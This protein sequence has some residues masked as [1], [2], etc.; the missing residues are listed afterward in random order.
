MVT[1]NALEH[2]VKCLQSLYKF[3]DASSFELIIV[4]N[5]S[6]DGTKGY[7][8][9]FE[10][11]HE[12]CQFICN[13]LNQGFS[14][15]NNKAYRSAT[16][17]YIVFLN[18]DTILNQNWLQRLTACLEGYSGS[19]VGAVGPVSCNSAGRQMVGKQD[20]EEWYKTH[21]GQWGLTGRLFGWC[22]LAKREMLEDIG[23]FDED[24][25]NG[26]E[27]NDLSFR[28]QLKGW[29]LIIAGDTYIHHTGQVSFMTGDNWIKKYMEL[30]DKNQDIFYNKYHTDV[31]KK[32]VAVYRTGGGEHLEESLRQTS[33]FADSII[34]H[35][36]RARKSYPRKDRG[37]FLSNA[38]LNPTTTDFVV[39]SDNIGSYVQRYINPMEYVEHLKQQFP[40]IKKVEFYDGPFQED[41]ERNWLLQEALKM[42]AK[43]EADWC[44]SVDDDEI[45]EDK[46]VER[47][48]S[49]M[50]P[51]N[52]EILGYW[53]RWRTIWDVVDGQE[54]FRADSTF[55]HF[56]NYRFFKLIPGQ[57]ITSTHPEGHHCFTDDAMITFKDN[58]TLNE[59]SIK[60]IK[61]GDMV[62]T[63]NGRFKKVL[64]TMKRKV[65]QELIDLKFRSHYRSLKGTKNHPFLIDKKWKPMEKITKEDLLSSPIFNDGNN[66]SDINPEIARLWG[67]FLSDGGLTHI[68]KGVRFTFSNNQDEYAKDV[69]DIVKKHYG[70]NCLVK[71]YNKP[72]III[73]SVYS[74]HL[75]LMFAPFTAPKIFPLEFLYASELSRIEFLKGFFRGDGCCDNKKNQIRFDN[76][77][78]SIMTGLKLL[79][80]SIN[81][82]PVFGERKRENINH[83]TIYRLTVQSY[84]QAKRLSELLEIKNFLRTYSEKNNT[85]RFKQDDK[86]FYQPVASINNIK[87]K[88]YV[89]NLEVE[90]DN[91]YI[92]NGIAVHNCGSAPQIPSENLAWTSLRV[93]HLGYDTPEQRQ[94]KYEFYQAND[95]F[96]DARDIGNKDYGHLIDKKVEL[97]P[98]HE[99]NGISLI[100]TIKNEEHDIIRCLRNVAPVIDEFII[101]DTGS[102]D[103]TKEKVLQFAKT[104][105]VPVKIFDYPWCDN[106][107]KAKNYAKKFATERW[108][109][110]IDAD[111]LFDQRELHKIADVV[112]HDVDIV[113][114]HVLNYIKEPS[115]GQDPKY[116]STEAIRL[117]LNT[118]ELYYTGIVHETLDDAISAMKHKKVVGIMR[119]PIP[120]HH[121]GY[122]KGPKKLGSKFEYYATLNKKQIEV[123]EGVDPRPFFNLAL[124]RLN[125]DDGEQDALK[126]F[127]EALKIKPDFWHA[128]AQMA[129]LN[130]KSAKY[131]LERVVNGIR[132]DHAYAKEAKEILDFLNTKSIGYQKVE[133]H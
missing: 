101:V 110:N 84:P 103:K 25:V 23:L 36:C 43:G 114:F 97:R 89:Y 62:L 24:L 63:H 96:K 54:Y 42:Q 127:Q 9:E 14:K 47:C 75:A 53:F 33:K 51:S 78:L 113:L 21:R 12:N 5:A 10:K 86:F 11:H 72:A 57:V 69:A 119:S 16:G 129:S 1:Y 80:N 38:L 4:D 65:S 49:M 128:N 107:S 118:P 79:L 30:G 2:T 68:P 82:S 115:K 40:K 126:Y 19:K 32:L 116:A 13:D 93:K 133:V 90:D 55:G 71:K 28:A 17:R 120:L 122:L 48:Q 29:K 34:L 74:V 81:I 91:S 108:V 85:S 3:T 73:V 26:F 58:N 94:K 104:S 77:S 45:Y 39:S 56:Q 98:Y 83:N 52:P 112:E 92:A 59:K 22:I 31:P 46:F 8:K 105:H 111:E 125:D 44:I 50:N 117:Y 121:R 27:D 99:S 102:T 66:Y 106:Y 123:T 35:F 132:P 70:L 76:T 130:I 64:N 15:A 60:D 67:Y 100:M 41:Y 61:V 7:L 87:F 109:L 18:N 124:H 37:E 6:T 88:G 95:N 131:F 20:P